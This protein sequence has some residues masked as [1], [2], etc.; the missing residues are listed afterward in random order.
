MSRYLSSWR[1]RN[2]YER[3]LVFYQNSARILCYDN[4]WKYCDRKYSTHV[5]W[6]NLYVIW[7]L[8]FTPS[9]Y[10]IFPLG[11][12]YKKMTAFFAG[13]SLDVLICNKFLTF[14]LLRLDS[15]FVVRIVRQLFVCS[16]YLWSLNLIY[17]SWK[18]VS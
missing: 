16:N 17:I 6:R 5:M 11:T 13:T 12:T 1:K 15:V 8:T 4:R 14:L 9:L 2:E 18:V 10:L 7:I 3:K